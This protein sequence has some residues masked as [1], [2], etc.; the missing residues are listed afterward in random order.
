MNTG[1]LKDALEG[2][3]RGLSFR[4]QALNELTGDEGIFGLQVVASQYGM[5]QGG[6]ANHLIIKRIIVELTT[7]GSE[8]I[9]EISA[10]SEAGRG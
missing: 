9:G 10:R 4:E 8:R 5:I 6:Q 1:V 7:R 3:P 2:L